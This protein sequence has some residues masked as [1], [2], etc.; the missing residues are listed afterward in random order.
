MADWV[1][2]VDEKACIHSGLCIAA[3]PQRFRQGAAGSQVVTAEISADDVVAEAAEGCPVEAIR[4][5]NLLTGAVV[6]P[7]GIEE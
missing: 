3:A 2:S 6:A 7:E 1:L 4:V 5:R